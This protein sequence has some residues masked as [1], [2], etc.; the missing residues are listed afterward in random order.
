MPDMADTEGFTELH[1]PGP[2]TE[3]EAEKAME[4]LETDPQNLY[5]HRL[6]DIVD[7]TVNY[8]EMLDKLWEDGD[9]E[10]Y[11]R[12]SDSMHKFH[13]SVEDFVTYQPSRVVR[14]KE[15]EEEIRNIYSELMQRDD[16][17]VED[18]NLSGKVAEA[19]Q[20][21]EF[22]AT[23]EELVV[24]PEESTG[25]EEELVV[26][27]PAKTGMDARKQ[28]FLVGLNDF[29]SELAFL[30]NTFEKKTVKGK[31]PKVPTQDQVVMLHEG[32]ADIKKR[33]EKYSEDAAPE[34]REMGAKAYADIMAELEKVSAKYPEHIAI[35][36]A[37]AR[38]LFRQV[39]VRYAA[40]QHQ[41]DLTTRRS[42]RSR[43]AQMSSAV[44]SA[45]DARW[46]LLFGSHFR[47]PRREYIKSPD[48]MRAVLAM[49]MTRAGRVAPILAGKVLAVD[50]PSAAVRP[51]GVLAAVVK[52]VKTE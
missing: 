8:R 19:F 34:V 25:P 24:V 2:I 6:G 46:K 15:L 17:R 45:E 39:R 44:R 13:Q 4:N 41:L 43:I 36:I 28:E 12:M 3:E 30:V 7:E 10:G 22:P 35:D 29:A 52:A 33:L 23:E 16:E 26:V 48:H 40:V 21:G 27:P 47:N 11:L 18:I 37:A 51:Q 1:R 20:S 38:S 42:M 9:F 5:D 14:N 31:M 49:K 32:L 50:A